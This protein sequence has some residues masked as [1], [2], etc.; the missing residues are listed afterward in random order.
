MWLQQCCRGVVVGNARPAAVP[1]VVRLLYQRTAAIPSRTLLSNLDSAF[2]MLTCTQHCSSDELNLRLLPCC[3]LAVTT[4]CNWGQCSR[5]SLLPSR[6][7]LW[8]RVSAQG[9]CPLCYSNKC[10][11][12]LNIHSFTG[13]PD[14]YPCFDYCNA[15]YVQ[16]DTKS[17]SV[18]LALA[19]KQHAFC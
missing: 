18:D 16:P 14:L 7:T 17:E 2:E 19:C 15:T 10:T 12:M 4:V 3:C 13:C 1:S 9:A 11:G 5:T 8:H 6:H